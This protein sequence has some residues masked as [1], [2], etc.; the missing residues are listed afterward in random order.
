[1][2][3]APTPH[4]T[5]RLTQSPGLQSPLL[6]LH[7]SS[8]VCVHQQVFSSLLLLHIGRW[9]APLDKSS[10]TKGVQT[11]GRAQPVRRKR[12]RQL[13]FMLM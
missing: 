1:M 5:H 10:C 9:K 7:S 13:T 4:G 2:T 3:P 6:I 11:Q 12:P 8:P